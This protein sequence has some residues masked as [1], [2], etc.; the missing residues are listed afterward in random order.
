MLI[1]AAIQSA[2]GHEEKTEGD[3][4]FAVFGRVDQAAAAAVDAQRRL[5]AEP[6]PEGV[7]IR[8]RMG[9]HTR[10]RRA[11]LRWRVRRGRRPPGGASRRAPGTAAR[12]CCR[13]P[14][15]ALVFDELPVGHGAAEARRAPPQGPPARADLPARDR[16]PADRVPADPVAR[17]PAQQPSDPADE[18]RRARG[19]AAR[20]GRLLATT[21]LLTLTGPGGTG[22]TRLSLQLA[23][24]VAERVRRRAVVR[25]ARARPRPGPRRLADRRDDRARRVRRPVRASTCSSS[26]S[27]SARSCSS[28]TT[29]SRSSTARPSSRICCARV[30]AARG[31]RHE[32]G[33]AAGLR[34]AGVPGSGPAGP[35]RPPRAV[36]PREAQPADATSGRARGRR[37][38][39]STRRSGCSSPAPWPCR[40]GLHGHERERPGRRRHLRPA[41]RHAAGDRA[42]RGAGQAAPARGD[43]PAPGA[44]ARRAR[45]RLARPPGA[46]ADAARGDRLE[47]RPARARASGGCSPRLAVFVG[48]CDLATGGARSAARPTRSASRSSTG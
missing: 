13:R 21:R 47:L 30:R 33:A 6:W 38:S 9:L 20:G 39:R 31:H 41:P 22:K 23:A 42:G 19:G 45:R 36:R 5:A 4:I 12:S 3:G 17:Q 35:A 1:R 46:P 25:A 14:T 26:G 24:D 40:A 16:R 32:P 2:G 37:R 27:A 48:G 43:P 44:P 34:R 7:S 28:S 15:S 18:L 29:S 11:R 10:R 8:V